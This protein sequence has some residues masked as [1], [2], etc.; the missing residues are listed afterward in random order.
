VFVHA[1]LDERVVG[2]RPDVINATLK[3]WVAYFQA[4]ERTG[5][6][7][8]WLTSEEGRGPLWSEMFRVTR[9][10]ARSDSDSFHRNSESGYSCSGRSGLWLDISPRRH[11]ATTLRSASDTWRPRRRNRYRISGSTAGV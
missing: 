10:A 4:P 9:E 8:M 2:I 11:W 7:S 6:G 5:S 1:G 3:S